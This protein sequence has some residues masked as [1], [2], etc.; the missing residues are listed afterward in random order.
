MQIGCVVCCYWC[1]KVAILDILS[2]TDSEIAIDSKYI[3]IDSRDDH[4]TIT[5]TSM[6]GIGIRNSGTI[7]TG[8]GTDTISATGSSYGIYNTGMIATGSGNDIIT[9]TSTGTGGTG[10][11]NDGTIDTGAGRDIVDALTGGFRG[12]GNTNLG[13]GDD[14]LKG[15]GTGNFDGGNEDRKSVV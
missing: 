7:D 4:D 5:G 14:T 12:I 10:I 8:A 11:Y 3:N 1:P 6:S 13:D 9:G 2:S 15:F